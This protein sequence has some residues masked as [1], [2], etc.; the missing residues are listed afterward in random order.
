MNE[1]I[2]VEM[3]VVYLK[4]RWWYKL[5]NNNNNIS[6]EHKLANSFNISNP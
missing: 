1:N 5:V 4:Y 2:V 3:D 6:K